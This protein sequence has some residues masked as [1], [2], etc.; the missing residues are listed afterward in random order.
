MRNQRIAMDCP[1]SSRL[2]RHLCYHRV[3][4]CKEC[5]GSGQRWGEYTFVT[6]GTHAGQWRI[7]VPVIM[8]TVWTG[9]KW[10]LGVVDDTGRQPQASCLRGP[11]TTEAT[12]LT[13]A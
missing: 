1:F 11:T 5:K 4:H 9:Q 7:T 13:Q 10:A 6:R 3:S 8:A 2:S 12:P